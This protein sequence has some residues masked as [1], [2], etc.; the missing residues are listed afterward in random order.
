MEK[1]YLTIDFAAV[2]NIKDLY[3]LFF[4]G[5]AIDDTIVADT[6]AIIGRIAQFFTAEW[7][8]FTFKSEKF[9]SN[10]VLQRIWQFLKLVF[11]A[12][13]DFNAVAHQLVYSLGS[14]FKKLLRGRE[15]CRL[16]VSATAKSIRSSL[17]PALWIR[18]DSIAF[19]SALDKARNAVR[20]ISA[21]AC[22]AVMILSPFRDKFNISFC[23]CQ[24]IGVL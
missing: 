14:S 18:P 16:R 19:C 11:C 2:G 17:R 20:K 3:K 12:W 9:W 8:W 7:P 10:A 1:K 15:A 6:Q 5:N 22:M 13:D 21:L 24:G 4:I 23:V